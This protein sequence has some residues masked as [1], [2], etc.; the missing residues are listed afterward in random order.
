MSDFE[1]IVVGAGPAG[2][3]CAALTAA[4][5]KKVLLLEASRFPR[6]KVCGDCLNPTAWNVLHRLDLADRVRQ[7]PCTYPQ[8]VRFSVAGAGFAE[9][10]LSPVSSAGES[11][12]ELVVRR[13]DLDELLAKRAVESGVLVR[14][15]TSVTNIRKVSTGWEVTT[16]TGENYRAKQIVASDGRNSITARFLGMHPPLKKGG[17]IGIQIHVPHPEG[18]DGSLEMRIYR[19]GYGGLADLGNGLANLCLVA[20]DGEMKELRKEAEIHYGL[21]PAGAWRS[22]TP[23]TRARARSVAQNGVFLCG[24][25]AQVVEPFTG[26]G[27]SFALR[28]GAMLADVLTDSAQAPLSKEKRYEELH[29]GLYAKGLWVNRLTRFLSEHPRVAN[30][31]APLILRYPALLSSLT[32]KVIRGS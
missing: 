19:H 30:T 1:I 26:E 14:D 9:I 10:P 4:T 27:I 28:S 16:G 15:G 21:N 2:S 12:P 3:S 20:N 31:A 23:I 6:D 18:Y 17:R 25:A 24:D 13:R 8:R 11:A 7:L 29:R 32:S 5:G 22:V